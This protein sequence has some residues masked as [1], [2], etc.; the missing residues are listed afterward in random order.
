MFT[1]VLSLVTLIFFI[2]L[3]AGTHWPGQQ[4]EFL[5]KIL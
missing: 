5:A 4:K 1:L 2:T 3:K